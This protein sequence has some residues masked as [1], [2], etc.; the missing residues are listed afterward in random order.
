MS[1][2]VLMWHCLIVYTVWN[3][4]HF[5]N[6]FLIIDAWPRVCRCC[7]TEQAFA[8]QWVLKGQLHITVLYL[9]T[10]RSSFILIYFLFLKCIKDLLYTSRY[11]LH[12]HMTARVICIWLLW[13][14]Q[15]DRDSSC[16]CSHMA[17]SICRREYIT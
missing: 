6:V 17:P 13:S 15:T 9:Y 4:R 3:N 10:C 2:S 1:Q 8:I 14:V 12:I 7:S 16:F 5:K 11:A